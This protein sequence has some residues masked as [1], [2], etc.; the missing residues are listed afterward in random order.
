M[1]NT[2]NLPRRRQLSISPCRLKKIDKE[3]KTIDENI[4]KENEKKSKSKCQKITKKIAE[5]VHE[6]FLEHPQQ[7]NMTYF[8]H[9][10]RAMGMAIQTGIATSALLIHS[11]VPKFFPHTGSSVI[12]QLHYSIVEF[13]NNNHNNHSE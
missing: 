8:T 5:I 12:N 10:K 2:E 4:E 6:Y 1:D 3:E 9:F 7:V 13:D 11:I